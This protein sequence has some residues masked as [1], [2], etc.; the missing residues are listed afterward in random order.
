MQSATGV[1][2]S[3]TI[4][5]LCGAGLVLAVFLLLA[6]HRRR[7]KSQLLERPPQRTKL[8]RPAAYSLQCRVDDVSERWIFALMQAVSSG[9]VLGLLCAAVY[10]LL[11]GLVFGRFSLTQ[12]ASQPHSY[13]LI[14]VAALGLAATAWLIK[15]AF[16]AFALQKEMRN[17]QFGLRGE[18]AVAEALANGAVA[19][20]GYVSFHDVP[21]E[22]DWNIDHVVVGPGGI[23]VL[24]TKTRSR[25]K[26]T[27]DQPDHEVWFDGQT[28][29]FPWCEDRKS[30]VQVERN[31]GWVR[32]FIAGFAPK[33]ILVHPVIVVP[34]WYVRTQGKF[35]VKVMNAKYLAT[36]YLPA[37][38]R[39]FSEQQL[40]AVLRR[41]DERC[42]DL[43][44]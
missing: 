3:H 20:A 29:R 21:G 14:S 24:E 34:G 38:E 41:F 7:R 28:L 17:C 42:R 37:F 12:I 44:F 16:Q 4:G 19:A 2:W 43:E 33:G 39:K 26:P 5:M 23:F 25:R 8:L 15:S 18:Q 22:G 13:M 31:A 32:Q 9:A 35:S 11:E 40:Q 10:P 30:V 36:A 1:N 27:Y 6:W